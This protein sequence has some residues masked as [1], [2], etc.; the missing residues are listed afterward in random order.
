MRCKLNAKTIYDL[1]SS[2]ILS[3]NSPFQG[4]KMVPKN[5]VSYYLFYITFFGTC[6]TGSGW[7]LNWSS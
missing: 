4:A 1:V 5:K 2:I 3:Y 7:T 6:C